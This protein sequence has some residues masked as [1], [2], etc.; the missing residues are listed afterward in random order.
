MKIKHSKFKNTGILFELL[1]RQVTADTLNNIQSP[2]LNII[3]KYFIKS[4]LG[5][6]LKLYESLTKSQK[7]SETKSNILIVSFFYIYFFVF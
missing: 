2:A 7:L 1:V 4:E 5:K 6:E 3:K